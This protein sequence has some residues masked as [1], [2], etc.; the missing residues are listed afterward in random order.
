MVQTRLGRSATDYLQKEFDVDISIKRV[1]LSILGKVNFK[2]VYIKDHHADTLIYASN[3][4]SSIYS[5]KNILDNKLEFGEIFLDN[6]TLNIKTYKDEEDNAL[7]VFIDKFDDGTVSDQPSSFRLTSDKIYLNRGNVAIIDENIANDTPVFFKNIKGKGADFK[8]IGPNVNVSIYDFGFIENHGI[9]AK[10][11]STEFEYTLSYMKFLNTSLETE[12]SK[13]LADVAF[14]F[15]R[16]DF[17]DFNNKVNIKADL[18]QGDLS[19]IDLQKFYN[20]FGESD[21]THIT[22][23]LS[24]QLNNLI[25]TDFKLASD[26][27][28]VVDGDLNLINSFQT[29]NGFVLDA[30]FS[31]L[32][33]N[34]NQLSELLPNI[35]KN[36]I[37]TSF[38]K[39]GTIRLVGKTY[40]T[41]NLLNAQVAVN[42]AIGSTKTDLKLVNYQ[43]TNAVSY[44]GNVEI[45]NFEF[46]KLIDDP[47]FE[48]I[49]MN[50]FVN[51]KGFDLQKMNSIVKGNIPELV[52]NNYP[53]KNITLNGVVKNKIYKGEIEVN[54]DNIKL[55]FNGLANLSLKVYKYDFKAIV[56]H[57]DLNKL[58]IFKRDTISNLKGDIEINFKGN[59]VDN[60]DGAINFKNSL[61]TNQDGDYF[62][63]D[64]S[65]T[66]SFEDSTRLITINSPE[67]VEGKFKGQFK[68]YQISKLIQNSIG[69]NYSNYKPHKV[70][71]NQ[72]LTFRL[73][74][75]NKIVE[76]FFPE[77]NLSANT[78]ISGN[79]NSDKNLFKLSVKSPQIIAY[80][81]VIDSLNLQ[82]DNKNPIFNT[83]LIVQKIRSNV[84][85]ISD[86][87]LVNKTLNDT[88]HLAAEFKGGKNNTEQYSLSFYHTFN[89]QNQ[90]VLGINKSNFTFK[91]NKWIINPE[92]NL[93]NKF[94]YNNK[95]KT[96]VFEPFLIVSNDQRIEFKGV[97]NDT[98]SK[99]IHLNFKNVN[100]GSIT[101]NIDSLNLEGLVNGS[102]DYA[103]FGNQ[104]E[105]KAK[106]LVANFKINDSRQGD[107][108]IDIEGKNSVKQL[109]LDISLKLD[110][111]TSF[112]AV[113][114][115]DLTEEQQNIDV[116]LNFEAFKLD[117][118]SPLGEDVFNKIRG[119]AYGNV[120]IK[121]PLNNPNMEGDLFL[122]EAGMYFPYLNVDFDFK[123]TS[124][125]SLKDQVFTFEDVTIRDTKH[126]SN[127][128][129]KGTLSHNFFQNW[130]LNLD[131]KTK[132]L[133]VLDTKEEEN[134]LY[135]G[136][137][138]FEGEA[139]IK[140][141]TDKLVIDITGKTKKNTKFVLPINDVKTAESSE[142]IRFVNFEKTFEN[143]IE[144]KSFISEKLK[145]LSINFN[146]EVTK[147][148]L[149]EMV[150]DKTSGSNLRGSG[151]G[152]LLIELDTRDKFNMYGDFTVNNGVYDFKYGGIINKPF[153]V[154][155]GGTISWSGDPLTAE[156]DIEAIYRVSANPKILL[157]NISS[158]R[159]LPVDLITRFS[160][161]L[162]NS[163]IEFDIEIPNS[164][165]TVASELAFKLSNN[166][167]TQF[168]SLL[169]AG[170]F[171]NE[172][173]ANLNGNAAIYST[174]ADMLTN[175]FDNIFNTQDGKFKLKP[176]YTVGE[177][178]KVDNL[179]VS[180]Q[181]AFDM[182]YQ[183]NDRILINGKVGV[184]VGAE[185]KSSV[186]GE[187]TV[188]F[189]MNEAG[190]FR[191]AVFNRQNDIQYSNEEE[192]Y[193][194]G[195]GLNYQIDF[196]N[197][198]EFLEKLSLKKRII[199]DSI[200]NQ[201]IDTV[202]NQK[203]INF[204]NKKDI[205]NE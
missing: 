80:S 31:S 138:F 115:L 63:K 186:I 180:D 67:I 112:S 193:T 79:V 7:S 118:F 162:F 52:Y 139:K 163:D 192:G 84:Y 154:K 10:S 69:S 2:G 36:S 200:N 85:D 158:S 89:K 49:S 188:E 102:I 126:N 50:V 172:A 71:P 59:S 204:K 75:Y 141:P 116:E 78:I 62:F 19:L 3:L 146:L 173:E 4:K 30:N 60:L 113:G 151:T 99:D 191:L 22:T 157:E 198:R 76:L 24:G 8:I 25:F 61:Y 143:E 176:V 106:L 44:K 114:D 13:L 120:N 90:S 195:A 66:S 88:L 53:Y 130:F 160:G 189:L 12:T 131:I 205:K 124:V 147:D 39:F 170:T 65:I 187:V 199:K 86:L 181:L 55:H 58:N 108:N 35:V 184:P 94:V 137:A 153:I 155:R 104:I 32:I 42:T 74:I 100:L 164:S 92:N 203:L 171:Y 127:A 14:S 9:E 179:D 107:L 57:C 149:F 48:K 182:D 45:D 194:Q 97:I 91:N 134:S 109:A 174:G 132:N 95:T 15:D 64:F 121:G 73:E 16:E 145:G 119:L 68:F 144:R 125:I 26:K 136:T 168:I 6:F 40:L 152:N 140:G 142:L 17:S 21:Y 1:D 34:Y 148:A 77:I 201:V 82:I 5:F 87:H 122:D 72:Y 103:H 98:I 33:F 37:P 117:A 185:T 105:P 183:V 178:N 27:G 83:Q 101:P 167:N 41:E 156:I 38:E 159:K 11:F 202:L 165:S 111:N 29:E 161:G 123:G 81:N 46:G 190:T 54:D 23:K 18:K 133:L 128:S 20:E 135:Y 28:I 197:G 70:S 96:F 169:V 196:D 150:I 177:N 56:D 129:L 93:K 175:A 47:L 51:G 110:N 43:N 166:I